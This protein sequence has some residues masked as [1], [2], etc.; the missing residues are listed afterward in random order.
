MNAISKDL[1]F[2][3]CPF[4]KQGWASRDE[5]LSDPDIVLI[6]YQP[7]FKNMEEGLFLFKI[8]RAHV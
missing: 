7:H 1:H 8:G 6:G 5:F 2:K 3:M 4:C